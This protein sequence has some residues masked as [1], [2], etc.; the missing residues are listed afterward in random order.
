M[1][2]RNY[3]KELEKLLEG[4]TY[5]PSL[6]LHSCCGPC[7]SYVLSY[8]NKYF[9]I[10]VLY[11]NPNIYPR[12]EFDKRTEEQIRLIK[13]L[14]Q[15]LRQINP[16]GILNKFGPLPKNAA[17]IKF[18]PGRYEPEKFFEMA[19]GLEEL[20]EGGERCFKCYELRMREAAVYAYTQGYDYFTTTLSISPLKNAQKINEI[21]ERL[22]KELGIKHLP[23]DFKKRDGYLI[24]CGLCKKYGLYRQDYCGCIFSRR[25]REVQK[26]MK[27]AEAENNVSI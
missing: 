27:E 9:D 7:S 14:N 24:S 20:K 4:L 6:L 23:A 16:D 5:R 18:I 1:N 10:T 22:W 26:R 19:K 21:G 11:Y 15:D 25:E 12:E 13:A 17:D 2:N 3:Q 8:L